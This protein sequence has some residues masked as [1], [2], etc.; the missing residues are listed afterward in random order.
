M[1]TAAFEVLVQAS[2]PL[3]LPGVGDAAGPPL[4]LGDVRVLLLDPRV[5]WGAHERTWRELA[6]R[7]QAGDP[8]WLVAALGV[9]EPRLRRIIDHL[10]GGR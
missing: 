9:A 4:P 10:V 2:E 6:A 7:V 1:I 3:Q 8:V 5:G